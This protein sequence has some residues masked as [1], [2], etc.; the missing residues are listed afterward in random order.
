[1]VSG[2]EHVEPAVEQPFKHTV[3]DWIVVQTSGAA[4]VAPVHP[5]LQ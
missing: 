4:H 1:M 3:C 2:F 5:S